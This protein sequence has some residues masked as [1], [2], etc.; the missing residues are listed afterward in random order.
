[1]KSFVVS[2]L[3]LGAALSTSVPDDLWKIQK[4]AN[5]E[6][7]NHKLAFKQW[8]KEFDRTYAN[9]EEESAA[10]LTFLDNWVRVITE[11]S[12]GHTYELQLNQFADMNSDEFRTYIHGNGESCVLPEERKVISSDSGEEAVA[13]CS[14]VDWVSMG[15]VNPV[16]N[17]GGCGSCWAFSA[18]ACV[19]SR[20]AI[21]KGTLNSLSEQELVDCSGSYGN[22]GCSGGW[23][24]NGFKYIE[25]NNGLA[26]ESD[27]AY[28]ATDGTCES[29]K[30]THYD[31]ITG[32]KDVSADSSSALAAALCD[33]PVSIAIEADQYAFQFYS[34]GVLDGGCGTSLDHGV[35]AVGFGY[36]SSSG[37]NYWKVRNSWGT[38]WGESGYIRMCKDCDQNGSEGECGILQAPSYAQA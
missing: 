16:K 24:D 26:L 30:Y 32:Y 31:P 17:Q 19:E 21:A 25:A 36:D 8:Q 27:Y 38:S 3:L 18:V 13:T 4:S 6:E 12:K 14:S 28:T 37:L 15:K 23:M 5:F 10:F 7:I 2:S 11:N 33:G 20:Y 1:M 22:A 34:G 35:L 29:S 9:Y